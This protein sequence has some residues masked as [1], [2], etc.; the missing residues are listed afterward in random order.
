[1]DQLLK[2]WDTTSLRDDYSFRRIEWCFEES[3]PLLSDA[4]VDDSES[5]GLVSA[6]WRSEILQVL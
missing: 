3:F 2:I 4:A 5:Q 6:T 1:M